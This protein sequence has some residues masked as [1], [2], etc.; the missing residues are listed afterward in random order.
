MKQLKIL[1][2]F[3]LC[4]VK[5]YGQQWFPMGNI[6]DL[7][8]INGIRLI[9]S[10]SNYNNKIVTGGFFKRDS[11]TVL[12][13]IAQW[14]N[15]G[16]EPMGLGAWAPIS[17]D[18]GANGGNALTM[19]HNKFY[20]AGIFSG[21]GGSYIDEP[22]H[23]ANNIAKW[24]GSDW[25]PLSQ[26][27]SGFDNGVWAMQV[28]K[29]NLY[30]GGGF[31]GCNDLTGGH[32]TLGIARWNDTVF[33]A[34]GQFSGPVENLAGPFT[35][36]N[37]KLIAGGW[38]E[39]IDGV[40]GYNN[41][42]SYNDT[43]WSPMGN[44]FNW[45][46]NALVVYNGELYAGGTFISSHDGA[47]PI[48]NIAKWTGT[49]WVQ[50]GEGLGLSTDYNDTVL[51]LCVDS[52]NNK[53]YAGGT[54]TQTGLGVPARHLAEWNGTNWVE[55]GGGT[56]DFVWALFAKNG[57]LY[58]GG[59]FKHVGS[60]IPANL[61]AC[62]GS[63]PNGINEIG[64]KDAEIN[65]YPNPSNGLFTINAQGNKITELTVTNSLGQV[66]KTV[67]NTSTIDLS[68]AAKGIYFL[69]VRLDALA[70]SMQGRIVNKKII[71]E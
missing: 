17:I 3:F 53:L 18:S 8:T 32:N 47:T 48:N 15:N 42:A 36:F 22:S 59:E 10:I 1:A 35:I 19:Y 11:S 30:I 62:W 56:D 61:I 68:D 51:C 57:N 44:G 66:I 16:W 49:T 52:V 28:Y 60:G 14:N 37:D 41:I 20:C 13:G 69:E 21:A 31:G 46:V 25:Y 23:H 24:T 40:P 6:N 34:C 58:V 33:S 70:G 45:G 54:F 2:F 50:V 63:N 38:F 29:N 39:N 64:S 27:M 55:V 67:S 7:P 4:T 43:T 65:I 12:N 9:H 5:V 71:K 26:P